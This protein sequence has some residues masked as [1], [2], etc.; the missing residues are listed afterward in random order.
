MQTEHIY[1][2]YSHYGYTKG[3][4]MF[5]SFSLPVLIILFIVAAAAIWV[6]GIYLSNTTD[7]LSVRFHL[8]EALGGLIL[9]AIVTNL[10]EL[11]IIISAS[12]Q[13]HLGLATGDILGGIAM[14]TLVLVALDI[15]GVGR[16]GPLTYWGASLVLVIEATL[17]VAVLTVAVMG[18]QLVPSLIF[19]R[20]APGGLIILIIWLAGIWLLAKARTDLPWENKGDAPG[21]QE[22]AA[23]EKRRQRILQDEHANLPRAII[24]F[25]IS[26]IVTL[27]A[28]V[29]LEESGSTIANDVGL[30]GVLFGA[31]ILAATTSLP[32]LSTGIQAVKEGDYKLALSD[33]FGGNAFLPV[34][35]LL[36]SLLSGKAVLPQANNTDIY[37]ASLGVLL[38]AV[39]ICGLLFRPRFFKTLGIDSLIV[40]ILY[41]LGIIGLIFIA[42]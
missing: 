12:L 34:L 35:F 9:L 27:V 29:V 20:I 24:I 5:G 25:L 13:Q 40:L 16:K 31:T 39:Y 10:P 17:V 7:V 8:G 4:A 32:E 3:K 38:T 14:Q 6:A 36:A 42:Q 23:G 11:A 21:G 30:S 18:N 19:L 22:T 37:L 33:I 26:S 2:S 41:I 15:F 28:G 1:F